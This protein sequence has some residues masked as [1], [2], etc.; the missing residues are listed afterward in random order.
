MAGR[1]AG[2]QRAG[3]EQRAWRV[4]AVSKQLGAVSEVQPGWFPQLPLLGCKTASMGVLSIL[5]IGG[6]ALR[7]TVEVAGV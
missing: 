6:T 2:R 1:P 5:M 3:G 7:Q 4:G